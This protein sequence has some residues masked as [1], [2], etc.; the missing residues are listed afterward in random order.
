MGLTPVVG[1]ERGFVMNICF[2]FLVLIASAFPFSALAK[3]DRMS[4]NEFE[5]PSYPLPGSEAFRFDIEKLLNDQ[6]IRTKEQC[7]LASRKRMPSFTFFFK[8]SQV[9]SDAE[10]QRTA[11][12]MD[13]VA[14]LARKIADGQRDRFWRRLPSDADSRIEPCVAPPNVKKSYPSDHATVAGALSCVLAQAF[15]EKANELRSYGREIGELRAIA[16]VQ[17]ASD[18]QAGMKLGEE[19]CARLMADD[20]FRRDLRYYLR[21]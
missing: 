5:V 1:F 3:W 4:P 18:V 8:G 16:G 17:Y 13:Q 11:P 6:K 21:P 7:Q 20:D 12:L 19:I 9:L 2:A 10:V 14:V 15:P